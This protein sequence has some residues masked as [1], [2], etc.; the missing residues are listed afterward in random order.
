MQKSAHWALYYSL[1]EAIAKVTPEDVK[2]VAK[3]YFRAETLTVAQL[4]P[5]P[6]DPQA[7]AKAAAAPAAH[8]H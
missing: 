6:M 5:L 3:K 7:R 8:R 1:D 4:D 2:R